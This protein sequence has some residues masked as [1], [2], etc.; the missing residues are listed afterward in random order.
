M[1][2]SSIASRWKELSGE[3]NWEG[4]LL[5][6]LD[7]DFRRY[8][9]H[10]GERTLAVE[11]LVNKDDTSH[12]C[13]LYPEDE[14][15]TG[16]ALQNNN[17]FNYVVTNFFNVAIKTDESAWMGY[18]AVSTDD[19]KVALGRRDILVAWRGTATDA[20][21]EYNLSFVQKPASELFGSG[22]DA[23]VHLGFYSLYNG[24]NSATP[25][26]A[27]E[28]ILKAVRELVDKYKGEEM[29]IT[30]AGHSLGA[31]MATLNAVD[32]AF[33]G[34]N[35]P[36]G[37]STLSAGCMVTAFSY[38]GPRIGNNGLKQLVN[39]LQDRLH[40]LR[41]TNAQDIIPMVPFDNFIW[42]YTHLGQ[43]L[44]IDSSKSE[45]LKPEMKQTAP[46]LVY[47]MEQDRKIHLSPAHNL[48]IYLHTLALDQTG[49]GLEVDHDIALV[50]K[51]LDG[52]K[53][54]YMIP[55]NWW[56]NGKHSNMV[57]KDNGHWKVIV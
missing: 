43:E 3:K 6:P 32:I 42:H 8:L 38:A 25:I 57:Q 54:C 35:K 22:N 2:L 41:I 45:Y 1:A 56:D 52:L 39:T 17:T 10:Y 11:D 27:R 46:E 20:E 55:P 53:D 48:D 18:V 30:V 37:S 49:Y 34:Y 26:S 28:Q 7:P 36:T 51:S 47:E 5:P 9:I 15:F 19:A 31:A 4:L 40:I 29:S 13:S 44:K 23:K 50:N 24:T 16:A 21:W 33:N 14:F 12:I